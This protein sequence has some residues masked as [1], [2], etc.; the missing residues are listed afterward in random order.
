MHEVSAIKSAKI[1]ARMLK[2]DLFFIFSFLIIF[3][4]DILSHRVGK[5]K[6]EFSQALIEMIT[7]HPEVDPYGLRDAEDVVHYAQKEDQSAWIGR[8]LGIA[9]RDVVCI[10]RSA[11]V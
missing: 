7:D 6:G 11:F 8:K 9:M 3:S 1:S 10:N 5:C 2:I 4:Y